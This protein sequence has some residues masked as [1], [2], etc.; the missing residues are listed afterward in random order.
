MSTKN[1]PSVLIVEQFLFNLVKRAMFFLK[2]YE[3]VWNISP[4]QVASLQYKYGIGFQVR[5]TTTFILTIAN[6]ALYEDAKFVVI[7]RY[8]AE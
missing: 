7:E 1:D 8:R 5:V 2:S 3:K 4:R 6:I